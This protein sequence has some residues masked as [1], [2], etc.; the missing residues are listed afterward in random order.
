[1]VKEVNEKRKGNGAS[2]SNKEGKKWEI[3]KL[4]CV[5]T[6]LLTANRKK[7]CK[8]F[9]LYFESLS[10][11]STVSL[12]TTINFFHI[13]CGGKLSTTELFVNGSYVGVYI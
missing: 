7:N 10:K 2:L 8:C 11:C 4:I 13:D 9:T 1:M 5:D 12:T 3:R 6:A